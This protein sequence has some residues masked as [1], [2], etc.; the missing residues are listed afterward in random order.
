MLTEKIVNT[1]EYAGCVDLITGVEDF[2]SQVEYIEE[3]HCY[4]LEGKIIP[5]VTQLLSDGSYEGIN[6][7]LLEYAQFRGSLVHKEIET[8]L[9]TSEKGFTSEFY[10]FL[11]LYTRNKELFSTR[12]IFDYKTYNTN[13]KKNREKCYKQIQMYDKAL[14]YLTGKGVDEYYMIWL[15]HNKEGKIFNLKEEFE[16]ETSNKQK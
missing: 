11:T 9:K 15:P 14:E 16:N 8:Y 7:E 2:N 10:E 13:L 6:K 4:K 12:A 1:N 3:F 5:S